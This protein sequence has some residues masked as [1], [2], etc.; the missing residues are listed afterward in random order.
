VPGILYETEILG[1]LFGGNYW[2]FVTFT[3]GFCSFRNCISIS[4]FHFICGD[5]LLSHGIGI[6]S[7][8]PIWIFGNTVDWFNVVGCRYICRLR[9]FDSCTVQVFI[10]KNISGLI[11]VWHGSGYFLYINVCLYLLSGCHNTSFAYFGIRWHCVMSWGYYYNNYNTNGPPRHRTGAM[12]VLECFSTI[13][14]IFYLHIKLPLDLYLL[15][16]RIL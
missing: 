15:K 16:S 10:C 2:F 9:W 5:V 6:S 8:I 11:L 3:F 14:R 13:L 4:I 12:L 1:K 7:F